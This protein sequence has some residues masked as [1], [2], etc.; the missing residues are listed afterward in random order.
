[1]STVSVTTHV[2]FRWL[3]F[4]QTASQL[5]S[6]FSHL[7]IPLVGALLLDAKPF[8]MGLLLA[9]ESVPFLLLGLPAGAIVDRQPKR[10]ILITSD[11]LRAL[12]LFTIPLA[13]WLECLT[14][15]HLLLVALLVG[16]GTV[17]FDVAYMSY[18]PQLV[19]KEH[20]VDANAKLESTNAGARILGP[21]LAGSVVQLVG[22]AV[23]LIADVIGFL[24][25]AV[26]LGR[27]RGE[28]FPAAPVSRLR[29]TTDIR[30]GLECVWGNPM[31]RPLLLSTAHFNLFSSASAAV[32][33]LFA[34][35]QLELSATALGTA[36]ALG[37][38]GLL[39]GAAWAQGA[40]AHFGLGRTIWVTT[41]LSG[42]GALL[43][44]LAT[45]ATALPMLV[46]SLAFVGFNM[47]LYNINQVSLRQ[48]ITP[49]ELQGRMNATIRFIAWGIQPLGA[50]AGGMLGETIGLL[51]TLVVAA[52]GSAGSAFWILTSPVARLRDIPSLM[53]DTM[54]LT[55]DNGTTGGTRGQDG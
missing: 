13:Y 32:F 48:S 33:M 9:A 36:F 37:N 46:T 20:L 42:L 14:M 22:P 47:M 3:W 21:G 25:S 18:L 52:L 34:V 31:L 11:L 28:R 53:V 41:L 5:G 39:A 10:R 35:N 45:P 54:G 51:P 2:G 6:Q 49:T 40:S 30:E 23:A 16:V 55:T 17:F 8:E 26:A 19:G 50:L 1:M 15:A 4:A 7:A 24:A 44:P 12:V 38:V 29:L 43:V 27:I